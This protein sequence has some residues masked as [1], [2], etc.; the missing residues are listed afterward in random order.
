[1]KAINSISSR[2]AETVLK[3]R[4]SIK[5]L[6]C[7]LSEHGITIFLSIFLLM[8]VAPVDASAGSCKNK[9]C[10][11]RLKQTSFSYSVVVKAN[12]KSSVYNKNLKKSRVRNYSFPV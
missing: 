5:G 2:E 3:H 1:M 4:K 8:I 12:K 6:Y 11:C 10:G 7:W 9:K